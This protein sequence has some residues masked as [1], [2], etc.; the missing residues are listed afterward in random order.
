MDELVD[1]S[2][3]ESYDKG[4][5][6]VKDDGS[7]VRDGKPSLYIVR[8]GTVTVKISDSNESTDVSKGGVF[9]QV[10]DVRRKRAGFTAMAKDPVVLGVLQLDALDDVH[11]VEDEEEEELDV[12]HSEFHRKREEVRVSVKSNIKLE[13]LEKIS[14]LGE[15]QFGEVWLVAADVFNT[16]M[17]EL[18]QKF[19]LKS[20]FKTDDIRGDDTIDA[21]RQEISMIQSIQHPGILDLVNTYEDDESIY[22]LM[23]LIPGGELWDAIHKE[24]PDTGEWS[25]GI[26]EEHAKFYAIGVADTLSFLHKKNV[27]FRDLKPE[28]VMIDA[29]GYPIIIDFGFAK[30]LPSESS[31]TYTF[32]GTPN[33]VAPEIVKNS[34]H[35]SGADYWALGVLIYEMLTGEN[36]FYFG[37]LPIRSSGYV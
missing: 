29:E 5:E 8:E 31:K 24:D 11:D 13:D 23:G 34:G 15:G 12:G 20:Q 26:P 32:C 2:V 28:N 36:P 16:G 1:K 10:D 14:L 30:E 35:N 6:I 22:M 33:Y 4:Q 18:K 3:D 7:N 25:S 37:T 27:V 19:A 17:D 21:I 9:P